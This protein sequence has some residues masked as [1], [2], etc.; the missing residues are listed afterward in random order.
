MFEEIG[1]MANL[2]RASDPG[3]GANKINSFHYS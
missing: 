1:S 2:A 3:V